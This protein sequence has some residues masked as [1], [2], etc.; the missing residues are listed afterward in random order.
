MRVGSTPPIVGEFYLVPCVSVD[1]SFGRDGYL[2]VMG[3]FH[4]DPELNVTDTHIHLDRRFMTDDEVKKSLGKDSQDDGILVVWAKTYNSE[5]KKFKIVERK[6]QCIREM[7][8]IEGIQFVLEEIYKDT[9]LNCSTCPHRKFD[10]SSLK[11]DEHGN[12]VCPGHG[13]QWNLKTGCVVPKKHKREVFIDAYLESGLVGKTQTFEFYLA[14]KPFNEDSI[15]WNDIN[16]NFLVTSL[17][18]KFDHTKRPKFF[19]HVI[20][21]VLKFT[22]AHGIVVTTNLYREMTDKPIFA[23]CMLN[24]PAICKYGTFTYTLEDSWAGKGLHASVAG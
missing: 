6:M 17:S 11:P 9:K 7:P 14:D 22:E 8:N 20:F 24:P 5:R 18:H 2:P 1:K 16:K 21:E 19:F 15:D 10:L 13:L 4:N 12:V 23:H 3:D